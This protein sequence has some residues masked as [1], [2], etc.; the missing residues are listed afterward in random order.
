MTEASRGPWRRQLASA[1]LQPAAASQGHWPRVATTSTPL[2]GGVDLRV[3]FKRR[4]LTSRG[5][6]RRAG[7]AGGIFGPAGAKAGG[8]RCARS[9]NFS[10]GRRTGPSLRAGGSPGCGRGPGDA[11]RGARRLR[12]RGQKGPQGQPDK[13]G[14]CPCSQS[15]VRGQSAT[16]GATEPERATVGV[17]SELAGPSERRSALARSAIGLPGPRGPSLFPTRPSPFAAQ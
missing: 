14:Q 12:P 6:E 11:G 1:G 8:R 17:R 5:L 9:L 7:R 15:R 3:C 2:G 16:C 13:G 10:V 4:K